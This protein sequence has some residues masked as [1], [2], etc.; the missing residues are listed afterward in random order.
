MKKDMYK[1][2]KKFIPEVRYKFYLFIYFFGGLSFTSY[3]IDPFS[4]FDTR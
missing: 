3:E 2:K 1:L 4:I